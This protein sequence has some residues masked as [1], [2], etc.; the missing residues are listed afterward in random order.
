MSN[1]RCDEALGYWKI[2]IQYLHL[3]EVVIGE[4]IKQGNPFAITSDAPISLEQYAQETKWSDHSLVIPL[5]FDFYHGLEVLL[6]GFLVAKGQST[7]KNHKLSE[8]LADFDSEFPG[9]NF[10]AIARKYIAQDQLP[11]LLKAFCNES[12]ITIDEY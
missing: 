6:K 10:G 7:K 5:L 11:E 3:V 2:G 9:R 1:N 4:S 8:L 12:K